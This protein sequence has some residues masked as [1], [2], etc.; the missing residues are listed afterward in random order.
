MGLS[1][2]RIRYFYK[3]TFKKINK[4][5]YLMPRSSLLFDIS[6]VEYRNKT[7]PTSQ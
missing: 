5:L 1:N 4:H 3:V 6:F 2:G 7:P